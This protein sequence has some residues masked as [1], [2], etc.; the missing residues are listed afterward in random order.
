[1]IPI[2]WE[3]SWQPLDELGSLFASFVSE[4]YLEHNVAL[5]IDIGVGAESAPDTIWQFYA[6]LQLVGKHRRAKRL[7]NAV[8]RRFGI[9]ADLRL[10]R[11]RVSQIG[12]E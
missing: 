1:M 8:S 9:N 7:Q 12:S 6:T 11:R 4:G 5:T 10:F 3:Q 2:L